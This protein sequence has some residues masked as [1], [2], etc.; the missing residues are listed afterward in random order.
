M[1]IRSDASA[2]LNRGEY[3]PRI[4]LS[5]ERT[6]QMDM[7]ATVKEARAHPC[8]YPVV[9]CASGSATSV[10]APAECSVSDRISPILLC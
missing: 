6:K 5:I 2:L 1:T 10:V 8:M 9:G 4:V 7:N 3:E